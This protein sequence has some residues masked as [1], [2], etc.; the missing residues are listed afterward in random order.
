MEDVS[1]SHGGAS[2]TAVP[3]PRYTITSYSQ[4]G[5]FLLAASQS[6]YRMQIFE[7]SEQGYSHVGSIS[8]SDTC[9]AL[10]PASKTVAAVRNDQG[11]ASVNFISLDRSFV[12]SV[13]AGTAEVSGLRANEWESWWSPDMLNVSGMAFS[14]HGKWLALFGGVPDQTRE[15]CV[16]SFPGL[17]K[18]C[19][20]SSIE[21]SKDHARRF[22]L[23]LSMERG[24]FDASGHR[25]FIPGLEGDILEVEVPSGREIARWGGH[26]AP[27]RTLDIQYSTGTLVSLAVDGTLCLWKV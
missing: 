27:I 20:Y 19:E 24:V 17:S 10:D 5:C 16:Y 7:L 13:R 3:D 26:S 8:G 25:L 12:E 18:L 23:Q 21:I 6:N 15:V 4:C 14:K 22:P 1:K 11:G 2:G 9:L